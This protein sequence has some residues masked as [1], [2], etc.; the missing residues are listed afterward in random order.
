MGLRQGQGSRKR[1]NRG[2][3]GGEKREGWIPIRA[4]RREGRNCPRDCGGVH[5]SH[6]VYLWKIGITYMQ[7]IE[8]VCAYRHTFARVR[9]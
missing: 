3:K 8:C 2:G 4:S 7:S 5:V 1:V 9:R 6:N